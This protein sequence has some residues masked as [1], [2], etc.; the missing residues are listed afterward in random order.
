MR[1]YAVPLKAEDP[2]AIYGTELDCLYQNRQVECKKSRF[3][4]LKFSGLAGLSVEF[5]RPGSAVFVAF[6][7]LGILAVALK[8]PSQ[9]R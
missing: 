4:A 8:E 9:R 6:G 2:S 1:G 3:L 5:D 7:A